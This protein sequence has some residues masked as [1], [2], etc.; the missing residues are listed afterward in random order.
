MDADIYNE[1]FITLKKQNVV[2]ASGQ[3]MKNNTGYLY[4]INVQPDWKDTELLWEIRTP[5]NIIG[6]GKMWVTYI[7]SAA[8]GEISRNENLKLEI[9]AYATGDMPLT[10][11]PIQE[12]VS[13]PES[14]LIPVGTAYRIGPVG[15]HLE[16]E[17]KLM[18]RANSQPFVNPSCIAIY[19]WD[20]VNQKFE[21]TQ[22]QMKEAY[23]SAMV[24]Q[25][26]VYCLQADTVIPKFSNLYVDINGQ[27]LSINGMVSDQGSG[28][29]ENSLQI[30]VNGQ[31]I[32]TQLHDNHFSTSIAL[33]NREIYYVS[34]KI[35]DRVGNIATVKKDI[36]V[37]PVHE[38]VA[39]S[40]LGQ[41]YPNPANPETW[42]PY[43][44]E[45]PAY[46]T[47]RIYNSAGQL[48]RTLHLG[49]KAAGVY[50]TKAYAAYWD[51]R[52]NSGDVV[53]SGIYFYV[54]SVGNFTEMKKLVLIR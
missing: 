16:K 8:G 31:K 23:Y 14:E 34:V 38:E 15:L 35:E 29:R 36:K 28:I 25:G 27:T 19:R 39:R 2:V 3:M 50:E 49:Y 22:S 11:I 10:V 17:A 9:P 5:D 44:L 37:K 51:G 48:I 4:R 12:N 18:F 41:N 47:I 54:F 6:S 26:G 24:K 52:N 13:S 20:E 32:K 21:Y 1:C 53:A 45:A 7:L 40:C 30:T 46:V 43:Y 42:I 33:T